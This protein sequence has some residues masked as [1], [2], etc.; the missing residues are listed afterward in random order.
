MHKHCRGV[1]LSHMWKRP[2]L[3]NFKH[4]TIQCCC[5]LWLWGLQAWYSTFSRLTS[6]S[7][8]CFS[9]WWGSEALWWRKWERV[10]SSRKKSFSLKP[11]ENREALTQPSVKHKRLLKKDV[12]IYWLI[13]IPRLAA[14]FP[15]WHTVKFN[16]AA[17]HFFIQWSCETSHKILPIRWLLTFLTILTRKFPDFPCP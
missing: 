7:T 3:N 13:L 11:R 10:S 9:A 1:W 2:T 17:N 5:L 15:V 6:A 4:R 16:W 12:F 14:V 8:I